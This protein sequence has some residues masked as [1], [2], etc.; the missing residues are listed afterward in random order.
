MSGGILEWYFDGSFAKRF[1]P[2]NATRNGILAAMTARNEFTAPWKVFEGKFG[3]FNT[4]CQKEAELDK[5]GKP[6]VKN[7]YDS[8][9][10]CDK[11]GQEY[12]LLTNSFKV[13]SGGRFAA[14]SI[15]A[16]LEIIKK[17]DIKPDQ[18]QEI[19]AGACEVTQMAH[20]GEGSYRPKNVVAAQF[21][22]P[23]SIAMALLYRKVS[24]RH[25][26]DENYSDPKII[27]IMDKVKSYVDQ[28]AEAV[29]PDHYMAKVTMVLKDGRELQARVEYPRGDPEN[30]PTNEEIYDKFRELAGTTM[31]NEKVE[32]LLEALINLETVKDL[33]SVTPLTVR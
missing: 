23:F 4:H 14:T 32:R 20:F 22:L 21:S 2:G 12:Y 10:L 29:Y 28:E 7:I 17:H 33:R 27:E 3:F 18:V 30:K 25:Y 1:H 8:T 19:R 16:C 26:K 31:P 5:D 15:D 24:V 9:I 11:L 13:H 6:V